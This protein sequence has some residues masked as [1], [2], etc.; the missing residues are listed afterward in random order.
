MISGVYVFLW[1]NEDNQPLFK[2]GM[3]EDI[4][5]RMRQ[6]YPIY[7]HNLTT[8]W[9]LPC[10]LIKA[11]QI[12]GALHSLLSPWRKL[13]N[14]PG[15]T[16]FYCMSKYEAAKGV[17]DSMGGVIQS[18]V[19]QLEWDGEELELDEVSDM[20]QY[21]IRIGNIIKRQRVAL[22]VTQKGLAAACGLAPRTIERLESGGN[23]TLENA[24]TVFYA[25][26]IDKELG[27]PI[28]EYTTRQRAS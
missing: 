17:L 12:E 28:P 8:V 23:V 20:H 3:S 9:V 19:I 4:H 1:T 24:L 11:R 21:L 25:L 27:M 26:G 7:N 16:E 2:I 22:N 5:K 14:Y 10:E 18:S 15:G 13:V 6:Y